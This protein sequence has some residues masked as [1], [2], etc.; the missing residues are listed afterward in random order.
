M[1]FSGEIYTTGKNLTLPLAVTNL[2]SEVPS[3]FW[4]S[5]HF[6][7]ER[8]STAEVSQFG[9]EFFCFGVIFS[10]LMENSPFWTD[11]DGSWWKL[12]GIERKLAENWQKLTCFPRHHLSV[13]RRCNFSAGRWCLW[14]CLFLSSTI[15]FSVLRRDQN[16]QNWLL[17]VSILISLRRWKLIGVVSFGPTFCGTRNVPAVTFINLSKTKQKQGGTLSSKAKLA[18]KFFVKRVFTI[19]ATNAS[20]FAHNCKFANL[21]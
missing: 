2:T 9:R 14:Q 21:I 12:S 20:F 8:N 17:N 4:F 11:I 18:M 10:I 7:S 16:N 1:L 3:Y 13:L 15:S 19:F 5:T 6:F